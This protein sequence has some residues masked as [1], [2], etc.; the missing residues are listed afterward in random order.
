MQHYCFNLFQLN[1]H[2]VFSYMDD[3][4][5]HKILKF[6]G[7]G[8]GGFVCS[9]QL[10]AF[11]HS[12]N[13]QMTRIHLFQVLGLDCNF[14]IMRVCLQFPI[15]WVF[16]FIQLS[17]DKNTHVSLFWSSPIVVSWVFPFTTQ[18]S[19]GKNNMHALSVSVL[20]S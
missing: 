3:K 12:C 2:Q 8:S 10:H 11:S 17:H 13:C 9:F 16:P 19:H 1:S 5:M 18:F 7:R 14:L 6:W 15:T 20:P 4:N